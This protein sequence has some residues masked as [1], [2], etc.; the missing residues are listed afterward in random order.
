MDTRVACQKVFHLASAMDRMLIPHHDDWSLDDMRQMV[1]KDNHFIPA[2]RF[3]MG[4]KVQL[5]LAR[6]GSHAHG[7]NQVQPLVVLETRAKGGRLP[8]RCPGPFQWRDQRKPAFIEENQG[9]R[10]FMP[11]FLYA[12]RYSVSNGRWLH[13]LLPNSAVVV[14]GN[15]SPHGAI[16]AKRCSDDN[17]LET[18]PR[19][20]G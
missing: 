17:T 7:A 3:A 13:R 1:E 12:A 2:D 9:C 14:F 15:S 4:L 6:R 5:E 10:E 20:D 8:A 19:S 11:L 18:D 16:Y